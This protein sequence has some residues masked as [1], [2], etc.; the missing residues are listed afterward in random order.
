V[1]VVDD[2]AMRAL[3]VVSARLIRHAGGPVVQHT[4]ALGF[5]SVLPHRVSPVLWP[6]SAGLRA[7]E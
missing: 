5:K 6:A 7:S 1:P 4:G 3:E 2:A